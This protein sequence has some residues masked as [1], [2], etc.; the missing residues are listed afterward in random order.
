MNE[1]LTELLAQ[2]HLEWLSNPVTQ[3]AFKRIKEHEESFVKILSN[4]AQNPGIS[5]ASYRHSGINIRNT[6]AVINLLSNTDLFLNK[7]KS[8]TK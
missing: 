5:D 3:H 8:T 7:V 2:Q 4:D 6:R 1:A